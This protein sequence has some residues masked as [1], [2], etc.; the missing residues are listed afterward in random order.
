M[1]AKVDIEHHIDTTWLLTNGSKM[2]GGVHNDYDVQGIYC[3]QDSGDGLCNMSDI[4]V[5]NCAALFKE[6]FASATCRYGDDVGLEDNKCKIARS[7]YNYDDGSYVWNS[8]TVKFG[9]T[10][11]LEN[12]SGKLKVGRC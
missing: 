3:C 12:C 7:C 2:K 6:S 5:E 8:I 10:N 4:T 11:D 1:V 9:D